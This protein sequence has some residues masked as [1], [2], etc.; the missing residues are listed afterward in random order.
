MLANVR[1]YSKADGSHIT[2]SDVPSLDISLESVQVV[3][4]ETDT[5]LPE[6]SNPKTYCIKKVGESL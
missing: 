5:E 1:R 3:V 4:P 6:F 2:V